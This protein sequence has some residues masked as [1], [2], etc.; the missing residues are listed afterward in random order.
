M[1][2]RAKPQPRR[3]ALLIE[4]TRGY[5]RGLIRGVARFN[6]ECRRWSVYYSPQ[7][8]G[9]ASLDW[10]R[11]WGGDGILARVE[12]PCMA[13]TVLRTGLPV[14][15]LRRSVHDARL[16]SIGPDDEAV[17]RLGFGHLVERGFRHLGL[18]GGPVGEHASLDARAT[19]FTRLAREANLSC[20][21]LRGSRIQ[22]SGAA[23]DSE[24]DRAVRWLKKLEQPAGVMTANDDRGLL[25]LDACRRAGLSV[26]QQV[27]VIG[28]GNDDCLCDLSLPP[29][30]SVDLDPE[31]IGYEAARL[32]DRMMSGERPAA[33]VRVPP[34]RVVCRT[35]TDV[36]ATG[37][38]IAVRAVQ[39]IRENACRRIR[40]RD[41]LHHVHLSR[42]ALDPRVAK[43][44]GRSV[45]QEIRRVQI[46]RVK[47][48]LAD[49]TAPLKAIAA[50]A[51]FSYP[52]YMMRAFRKASG[53]TPSAFRKQAQSRGNW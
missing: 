15:D 50:E 16:P 4:A 31:R 1:P 52:E 26:P 11:A 39:F 22:L 46:E 23:W 48:L 30:T 10:L 53:Q 17:A 3:V 51:G 13:A 20:V 32:L 24:L 36:L 28:A 2:K 6:R 35:S 27:A 9:D 47:E 19:H 21:V 33:S 14:V 42:G 7:S 12:T 45:S 18:Y 40:V 5:A 49:S 25:L 41:V 29:L 44:L 37:D 43:V 38:P 8:P 34:G